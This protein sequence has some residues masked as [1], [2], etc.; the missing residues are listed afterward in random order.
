MRTQGPWNNRMMVPG[1][2][3][4]DGIPDRGRRKNILP[5]KPMPHSPGQVK[6]RD[7]RHQGSDG[8]KSAFPRFRN[9][10]RDV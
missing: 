9:L 1:F 3:I 5:P 7:H 6:I 2:I 10:P 4:D 8:A